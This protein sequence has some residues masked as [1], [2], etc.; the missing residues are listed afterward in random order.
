VMIC[1]VQPPPV[2]VRH[3]APGGGGPVRLCDGLSVR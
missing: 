2:A 1:I 3:G